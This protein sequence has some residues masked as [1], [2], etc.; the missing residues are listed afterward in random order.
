MNRRN[1]FS[2]L[3]AF[4]ATAAL[5]PEKLLWRPG[6]K[7]IS[8][9]FERHWSDTIID[10][11]TGLSFRIIR[12]FDPRNMLWLADGSIYAFMHVPDEEEFRSVISPLT[13]RIS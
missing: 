2:T 7:L 9:P 13:D 8:I 3:A 6:P 10:S 4:T 12:H 5:D 11:Q 1:F